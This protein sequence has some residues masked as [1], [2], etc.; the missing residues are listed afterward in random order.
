ML[1]MSERDKML[2][3][4]LLIVGII[5]CSWYFGYRSIVAKTDEIK[6]DTET[7]IS[8][9]NS[10]YPLFQKQDEYKAD[11][12][13]LTEQYQETL[14]T[15]A[16]GTT[17]EG[18]IVRL[19]HFE[20]VTGAWYTSVTLSDILPVYTFGQIGST[21][22]NN[23]GERVYITDMVGHKATMSTNFQ[24][25]Y[26]QVKEL[27]T[28]INEDE[29]N[30]FVIEKLNMGFDKNAGAVTGSMEIASYDITGSERPFEN[31]SIYDVPLGTDNIFKSRINVLDES[32][33][34]VLHKDVYVTVLP[35]E[36]GKEA[37]VAGLNADVLNDTALVG[38]GNSVQ[39]VTLSISGTNGNYRISYK[40][41]DETYPAD[42]YFEGV[43]FTCGDTID[44]LVLSSE[45]EMNE[46]KSAVKINI[47]NSS[48]KTVN[49]YVFG[50]DEK[51]P[52][53]TLGTTTGSVNVE[54]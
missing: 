35:F 21:N 10:L 40:V 15:F 25:T 26:S 39:T 30:Q 50:E 5:F 38:R 3:M 28:Y 22:P 13:T 4:V 54:N 9:Y 46:D 53:V 27:L 2:V 48:D 52:R 45:R 31:V 34:I 12:E 11:T 42:N 32:S 41:G 37:V 1:K 33:R 24:G 7:L 51:E 36:K 47:A 8:K 23:L 43:E 17:Q 14:S 49:L 16:N 20:E 6:A 19:R 29:E 44:L 18:L